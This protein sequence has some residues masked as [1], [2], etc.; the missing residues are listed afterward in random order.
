MTANEIEIVKARLADPLGIVQE[1]FGDA[2]LIGETT[3]KKMFYDERDR[4]LRVRG[5]W[6][7]EA[8]GGKLFEVVAGGE[9]PLKRQSEDS[10]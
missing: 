8:D 4:V 9:A 1:H 3:A 5:A 2:A 10:I 6:E 7:R